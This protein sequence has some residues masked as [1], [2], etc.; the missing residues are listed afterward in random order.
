MKTVFHRPRGTRHH[1]LPEGR[2]LAAAALAAAIGLASLSSPP[3]LAAQPSDGRSGS[4]DLAAAKVDGGVDWRSGFVD[5]IIGIDFAKTGFR[6]PSGRGKAE[7]LVRDNLPDL[8]RDK[9]FAI[10]LDSRRTIGD[11]LVSGEIDAETLDSIIA[12]ATPAGSTFDRKL[13]VFRTEYRLS[14]GSLALPFIRHPAPAAPARSLAY[15]P[16]R[17]YSGIVIYADGA[18]ADSI[19]REMAARKQEEKGI[20]ERKD[21][22]ALP[23]HGEAAFARLEPALFPKIWDEEMNCVYERN[24]AAPEAIRERGLVAYAGSG[25]D[26]VLKYESRIGQSPL[27]IVARGVFGTIRC[28][29]VIARDDA[30]SIVGDERNLALLRD[31]RVIFVLPE[32]TKK[33]EDR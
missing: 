8:V 32:T 11:C 12:S 13:A 21:S 1:H 5:A 18:P 15:K 26:I 33:F 2:D 23:V 20:V 31:A 6:L 9:V 28:D 16:G 7:T 25:E 22:A 29:V 4:D 27:R 10:P 19:S 30:L 3:F 14:L 17:G 24:M